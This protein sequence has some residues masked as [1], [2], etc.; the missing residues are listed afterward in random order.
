MFQKWDA[1][2]DILKNGQDAIRNH[3]QSSSRYGYVL[4]RCIC[5]RKSVS[6]FLIIFKKLEVVVF[7]YNLHFQVI[8]GENTHTYETTT[9][10]HTVGTLELGLTDNLQSGVHFYILVT[11]KIL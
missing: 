2:T 1:L 10:S 6:Q 8:F 11:A 9:K 4:Y 3:D 5:L 7:D